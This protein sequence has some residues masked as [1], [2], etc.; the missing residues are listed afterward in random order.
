MTKVVKQAR[1]EATSVMIMGGADSPGLVRAIKE[2]KRFRVVDTS[3][4]FK[5][6]ISEKECGWRWSCPQDSRRRYGRAR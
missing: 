2:D 1:D 3:G 6:L 5:T 4:D